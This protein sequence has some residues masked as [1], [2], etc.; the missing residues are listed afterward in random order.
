MTDLAKKKGME[1]ANYHPHYPFIKCL[2]QTM[3][4]PTNSVLPILV[5]DI[6]NVQVSVT[7]LIS[8]RV[9]APNYNQLGYFGSRRFA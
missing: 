9:C 2:N 4:M 1:Q 7:W 8:P 6:I 5:A 3:F